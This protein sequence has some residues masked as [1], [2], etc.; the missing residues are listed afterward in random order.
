[1][2][3]SGGS[4]LQGQKEFFDT[5]EKISSSRVLIVH[6]RKSAWPETSTADHAHPF[7]YRNILLAHNGTIRDYRKLIP[8]MNE[9]DQPQP[10]ALDTEVY[11]HYVA[12]FAPLGLRKAFQKAVQHIKKKIPILP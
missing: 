4:I 3:K 11:L 6:I 7:S 12:N 10:E 5:L 8:E 9:A 1:V 2:H